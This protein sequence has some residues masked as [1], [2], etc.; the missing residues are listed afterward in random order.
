MSKLVQEFSVYIEDIFTNQ[1]P[2]TRNQ[3]LQTV[4]SRLQDSTV[5]KYHLQC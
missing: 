1:P 3:K 5:R 2:E 4:L